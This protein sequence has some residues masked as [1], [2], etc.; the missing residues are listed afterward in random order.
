MPVSER[1]ARPSCPAQGRREHQEAG[2][3]PAASAREPFVWSSHSCCI[4]LVDLK[5]NSKP[6][7]GLS[8]ICFKGRAQH[9]K[10]TP[11]VCFLPTL[12]SEMCSTYPV[13]HSMS[14]QSGLTRT[15]LA[16][17]R[18]FTLVSHLAQHLVFTYSAPSGLLQLGSIMLRMCRGCTISRPACASTSCSA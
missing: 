11:P 2:S 17:E 4:H 12:C 8:I 6:K 1:S 10:H 16:V 14:A 13:Q 3:Q 5:K 9:A 7:V 18:Y 15:A